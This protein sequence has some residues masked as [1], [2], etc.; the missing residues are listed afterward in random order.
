MV[1]GSSDLMARRLLKELITLPSLVVID[2]V[3]V[4]CGF[5]RLRAQVSCGFMDRGSS[6]FFLKKEDPLSIKSHGIGARSLVRLRDKLKPLYFHYH[7]IYGYQTWQ[8]DELPGK[9]PSE[10]CL[11]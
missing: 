2:I 7:Y 11:W 6:F 1:K 8:D 4:A 9:A 3:V 10:R 5:A